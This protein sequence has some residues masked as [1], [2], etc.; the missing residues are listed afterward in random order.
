MKLLTTPNR[1]A[2][3]LR[4]RRQNKT[5]VTRQSAKPRRGKVSSPSIPPVMARTPYTGASAPISRKARNSRRL[6]NVSLDRNLGSEIR[7]PALP[8]LGL[9]WR[10]VSFGL[11]AFL[12]FG[13]YAIW[14]ASAFRVDAP[15]IEGLQR[16]SINQINSELD[17]IGRPIFSLDPITLRSNL[18]EAFPEFSA[19]QVEIALPD[20]VFITVTERIPV[21]TWVQDG[22]SYLVDK[23]G[24]TFPLRGTGSTEAFPTIEA[25]GDPPGIATAD[26][27]QPSLR[28]ETIGKITG[29][30][31]PQL[32]PQDQVKPLLSPEFVEAV[33]LISGQSPEGSKMLYDPIHGLGWADRRG[34]PV[35][36]GS[37][38]DI[39]VKL[40]IY[41]AILEQLKAE[42]SR[43]TMISVEHVHAPFF[44]M[45]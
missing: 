37:V 32:S 2:E 22:K 36:L 17:L 24:I 13:L 31:I 12:V 14:Q 5:N 44:R 41:R 45:E 18:L 3:E 40:E 29:M 15:E 42:E 28:D 6:Y 30:M 26:E 8:Q 25:S 23:N 1:R 19:A 38:E 27:N 11:T 20:T 10:L 9:S 21:L 43:P 39:A 35:Y 33:L 7:L 4:Q 34:W 16:L